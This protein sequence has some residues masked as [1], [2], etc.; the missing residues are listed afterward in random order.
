M[1]CLPDH[2]YDPFNYWYMNPRFHIPPGYSWCEK[3]DRVFKKG[4]IVCALDRYHYENIIE[5]LYGCAAH[6]VNGYHE[7][8]PYCVNFNL[9][10]IERRK[11]RERQA[12]FS[13][14][15]V[16]RSKHLDEK[17]LNCDKSIVFDEY[18]CY[19]CLCVDCYMKQEPKDEEYDDFGDL[20]E[21]E[22]LQKS[23]PESSQ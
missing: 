6:A 7:K 12:K 21:F 14:A 3:H 22:T 1:I 20:K 18:F 8:C 17:C 16:E 9:W 11:T 2:P 19:C 15:W 4:C 5:E 10:A 13:K 23:E